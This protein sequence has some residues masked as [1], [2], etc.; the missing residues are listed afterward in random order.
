MP[1]R[2]W[3]RIVVRGDDSPVRCWW[4]GVAYNFLIGRCPGP[5]T[6]EGPYQPGRVGRRQPV[7]VVAVGRG[8]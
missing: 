7:V 6:V 5:L 1:G 8:L 2:P 3:E 4:W